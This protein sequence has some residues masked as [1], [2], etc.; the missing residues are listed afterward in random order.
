VVEL[1]NAFAKEFR[2]S[3]IA[4]YGKVPS[5]AK[6][7]R[8]FTLISRELEPVSVETIRKWLLGV[9]MP[10]AA[11]MRT[12]VVWLNLNVDVL[13]GPHY[14]NTSNTPSVSPKNNSSGASD[15]T[16]LLHLFDQLNS[17]AQQTILEIAELYKNSPPPPRKRSNAL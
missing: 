16:K 5:C 14:S 10:H 4:H 1:K 3:L 11:R 6:I 2:R 8:D 9:N 17:N 13:D 12:L 15:S 7:A